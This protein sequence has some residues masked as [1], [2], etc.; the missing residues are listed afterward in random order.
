[1]NLQEL[2]RFESGVVV[3]KE[4]CK[5]FVT[6]WSAIEGIPRLFATGFIGL[7]DGDDLEQVYSVDHQYLNLALDLG[8]EESGE[9]VEIE[10]IFE[11]DEVAVFTFIGWN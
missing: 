9:E 4:N 10:A 3:F 7:G 1:M 6:N 5:G 2:T 8:K 11:N